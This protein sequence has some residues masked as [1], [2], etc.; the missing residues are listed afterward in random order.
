MERNLEKSTPTRKRFVETAPT[1]SRDPKKINYNPNDCEIEGNLNFYRAKYFPLTKTKSH[2]IRSNFPDDSD[3]SFQPSLGIQ[4]VPCITQPISQHQINQQ[5][6]VPPS[7]HES[8]FFQYQLEQPVMF[9]IPLV[10]LF[11]PLGLHKSTE[12]F[13]KL[14]QKKNLCMFLSHLRI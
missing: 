1:S 10:Y 9:Y 13:W 5:N 11:S 2:V 8:S 3:V 12:T 7:T 6:T 4:D 14:S